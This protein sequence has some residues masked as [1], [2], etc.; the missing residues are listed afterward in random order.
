MKTTSPTFISAR[1]LLLASGLLLTTVLVCA[2]AQEQPEKPLRITDPFA[3]DAVSEAKGTEEVPVRMARGVHLRADGTLVGQVDYIDQSSLRLYP[4]SNAIVTF[5]QNRAVIAQVRTDSKGGFEA[6]GLSPAG[7][8]SLFVTHRDWFSAMAVVTVGHD[9]ANSG[10]LKEAKGKTP[11]NRLGVLVSTQGG[12]QT[13][14]TATAAARARV[15]RTETDIEILEIQM[16]P[17]EDFVA[18]L[19]TGVLGD[20]LGAY[21]SVSGTGGEAG[22]GGVGKSAGVAGGAAA[23][24]GSAGGGAAGAV[25]GG[26]IGGGASGALG[27]ATV[28]G[29]A[30]ASKSKSKSKGASPFVP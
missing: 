23:A 15:T 28:A 16:I 4:V 10:L 24:L 13:P 9:P 26:V 22:G 3:D 20:D 8:Y 14:V 2:L 29:A 27:A 18:A 1:N 19:R 5:V 12:V 30:A 17:R 6:K 25:G 21:G 7:V 11:V